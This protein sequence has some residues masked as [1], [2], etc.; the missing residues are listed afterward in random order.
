[1]LRSVRTYES[2]GSV[3]ATLGSASGTIHLQL[4]SKD[5]RSKERDWATDHERTRKRCEPWPIQESE[6]SVINR[7]ARAQILQRFPDMPEEGIQAIIETGWN[8]MA[9]QGIYGCDVY[10]VLQALYGLE[11]RERLEL[12][13]DDREV[14][15][16][17][18]GAEPGGR[19]PF[20]RGRPVRDERGLR[21]NDSA[22]RRDLV[23][24][25]SSVRRSSGRYRG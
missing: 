18:G 2:G 24:L 3:M 20:L 12:R 7:D 5:P 25:L 13:E 1:M 14:S 16:G 21:R 19:V 22:S 11:L 10:S 4:H 6:E 9:S 8:L 17:R 15:G 23:S